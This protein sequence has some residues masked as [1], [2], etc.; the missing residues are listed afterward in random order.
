MIGRMKG[1]M[2]LACFLGAGFLVATLLTVQPSFAAALSPDDCIKCHDQAPMDIDTDGRRHKTDITCVDCHEGH[3]PRDL[4]IIPPC[5]NCHADT[6]HFELEGCMT[7]HNNP[8]TPLT[9]SLT[10]NL[11]DPCLTCHTEQMAQLQQNQS[12]HTQVACSK[13]HREKHGFIPE[14]SHCHSPHTEE[15]TNQ[16]CLT[17]H[18][19][20]MPLA[21]TYPEDTPSKSCAACHDEA[22][23]LLI[24]SQYKHKELLCATCHKEKHMTIPKCSDC[25]GSPH[26]AAM[27]TKFPN[28][29]DC[30][31][32]AHD[33]NK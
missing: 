14:C 2:T 26:P 19:P 9:I 25:H 5:S 28:C 22:Y 17:C 1:I 11:T 29:G 3:P 12:A 32:L 18:M 23:E 6:P 30:H 15:M 33:L 10:D 20:H 27:M 13:C 16:D 31:G 21:V 7:C 24:A 8:H 4:D